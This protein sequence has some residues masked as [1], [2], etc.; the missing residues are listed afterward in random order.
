MLADLADVGQTA[1]LVDQAKA[2]VG[3]LDLPVNNAGIE[4]APAYP[5]FTDEELAVI[6]RVNLIAPMVLTRHALPGTVKTSLSVCR[7]SRWP[8]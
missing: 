2:T 1:A 5:A 4:V 8:T 6:A 7:G 3:P